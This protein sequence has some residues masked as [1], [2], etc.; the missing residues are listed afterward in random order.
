MTELKYEE[1]HPQ[2]RQQL[3]N[4]LQ[5]DDPEQIR[6]ALYS[7][8]RYEK[9]WRWTQEYCLAFLEHPDYL[10]RWAAALS[11]GYVALVQKQLD[12]E[13]VLPAMHKAQTDPLIRSTVGD[14]LEMI[15][16]NIQTQ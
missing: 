12:L 3:V 14:S 1:V 6:S 10:V 15:A 4:G 16:Q 7:A 13:R 8:A 11:L 5:S 9:D 2:S